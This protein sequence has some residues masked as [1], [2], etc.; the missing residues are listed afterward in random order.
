M[1]NYSL[2][3]IVE[4]NIDG[5]SVNSVNARDLHEKLE[6]KQQ[7]ADWI[8][9][10]LE[11]FVENTDYI[12]LAKNVEPENSDLNKIAEVENVD[13]IPPHKVMKP[14]NS[15]LQGGWNK[16]DYFLTLNTAK[17]ICMLENNPQGDKIRKYFIECEREAKEKSKLQSS[18]SHSELILEMAKANVERE[19]QMKELKQE[20]TDQHM[21][22]LKLQNNVNRFATNNKYLTVI[23]FAN[24]KNVRAKD[25]NASA[26]GR[27]AAKQCADKN[28]SMGSV[29][30]SRFGNIKTYPIEILKDIFCSKGLINSDDNV[31]KFN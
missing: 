24:M 11:R 13:C 1:A 23:A 22:M 7:F 2:I 28:I 5:E 12:L 30:D 26:I 10:R 17:M 9:N 20:Q 29:V 25:Y 21:D 18:L 8:K 14:E 15:R 3:S 4:K 16:I 31:I 27:M 6:S 19:R